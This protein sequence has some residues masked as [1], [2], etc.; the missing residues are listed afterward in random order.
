MTN[1]NQKSLTDGRLKNFAMG[2][3]DGRIGADSNYLVSNDGVQIMDLPMQFQPPRRREANS[4][5]TPILI[6]PLKYIVYNNPQVCYDYLI[7]KGYNVDNKIPSVYQYA[8]IYVKEYGDT[9]ILDM[10][11]NC[12]P[13]KDMILKAC[14]EKESSFAESTTTIPTPVATNT[15]S[16]EESKTDDSW[17]KVNSKTIII[18]LAVVVFFLIIN[19]T[20]KG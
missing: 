14:K 12:H 19:R 17:I 9:G 5:K 15:T 18:V 16:K 13:D 7:N 10:I 3:N 4:S 11:K 6:P 1:Y 8:R 2:S 20:S